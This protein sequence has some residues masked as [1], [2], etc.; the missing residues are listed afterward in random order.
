MTQKYIL[1]GGP[2]SGKSSI[3]RALEMQGEYTIDEAAEDYIRYRQAQGIAEPWKEGD[4]Q[5]KILDLQVQREARTR[6]KEVTSLY[7]PVPPRVFIDRGIHD[8]LAYAQPRTETYRKI[9]EEARKRQYEKIFLIE[10][11]GQTERTGV[12]REDQEQ[13]LELERKLEQIYESFGFKSIKIPA[14][15][16]QER[17]DTLLRNLE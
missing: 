7:N 1:T 10:N 6:G 9:E 16:L 4:F 15:P 11:L 14:A 17:V 8:G 12:R 13:A 3:I 2:G 5:E